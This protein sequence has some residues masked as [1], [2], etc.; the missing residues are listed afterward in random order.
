MMFSEVESY[1]Y[2]V[3]PG[4]F[5]FIFDVHV[6]HFAAMKSPVDQ[7]KQAFRNAEKVFTKRVQRMSDGVLSEEIM[8]LVEQLKKLSQDLGEA[9]ILKICDVDPRQSIESS[10]SSRR[11]R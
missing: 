11:N 2:L 3:L 1:F 5:G 4:H 8:A 9:A 10:P 7:T 6:E